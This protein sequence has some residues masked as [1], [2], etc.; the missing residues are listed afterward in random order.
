MKRTVNSIA[1]Y[2]FEEDGITERMTISAGAAEFP[3]DGDNLRDL[4]VAADEAMYE[5][6]RKG[7][8]DVGLP[9]KSST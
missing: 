6:K 8:N 9:D 2:E 7:G 4:I 5:V 1:S 3:S